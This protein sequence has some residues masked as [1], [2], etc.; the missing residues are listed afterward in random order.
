M[1]KRT[2][3]YLLMVLS[4]CSCGFK[5]VKDPY[6]GSLYRL[7]IS[8]VYPEGYESAVRAGVPVQLEE[9]NNLVKYSCATGDD[10][11]V[12]VT[13]P[14][15]MYRVSVSD[16]KGSSIFNGTSDKFALNA[17]M[18]LKL[19]LSYSKAGTL[20]I[21]EIYCGGC[22][23]APAQGMY[24]SDKYV[25]LHNNGGTTEYLDSLCFGTLAPYNS[26]ATNP[27][28]GIQ[29]FAPVIQ[30]V[31]QFGG[32]GSSFPL[33][34]GEDAVLCLNGAV[35][36]TRQFPLSVNLNKPDYFVCYNNTYFWNTTYH[37][38]PGDQIKEDHILDVVEK[39]GQANAY[40]FSISSPVAVIFRPEE[41]T[42]Q[43]YIKREGSVV[44]VPGSTF[45]RVVC[46]PWNW[47][48]DGVEVFNGA[49]SSNNKRLP[50]EVDAGYVTQRTSGAGLSVMRRTDEAASLAKGYEVLM[51]TNNSS[52]D[53]YER[54]TA[55]LHE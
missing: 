37:P 29:D 10:A 48:M 27:W 9:I 52:E 39:L 15:G 28:N 38:A 17:D 6:N 5:G 50:S 36:H 1:M 34:P 26:N 18:S 2:V 8:L 20:V 55:S 43:E 44:Q 45:D 25:I 24:Q 46:V 41:L 3:T 23:K 4:L 51:D 33:Q 35:D 11:S 40:T 12:R 19:E 16:R 7:D 31:W 49:A 30:A 32:N 13:L 22:D 53:F 54:Q 21:K 14:N 47:I 42:I